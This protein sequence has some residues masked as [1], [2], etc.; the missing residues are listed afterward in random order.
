[1]P[2][3]QRRRRLAVWAAALV[4][5]A[6]LPTPSRAAVLSEDEIEETSTELGLVAR[7]FGFVL[8]GDVLDR[9]YN[10]LE[11]ASPSATNIFDLRPYFVR[12]TPHFHLVLHQSLTSVSRSHSSLGAFAF[13]R[14]GTPPRWFPLRHVFGETPT[15]SL[16]TETDWAYAAFIDGPVT[17]TIGRQPVTLGRGRIWRPWDL[18]STFTLTEVDTEYKPGVDAVRVDVS[19]S[20]SVTITA[21]G[22]AG[23]LERD[24]DFE[25]SPRGSTALGRVSFGFDGGEMAL[26][27][28]RVRQDD[29][30]GWSALWALP[31]F[32]LYGELSATWFHHDS[33]SSP[34]VAGR[35]VAV[36]RG[37]LGAT[38]KPSSKLT[39]VPEVYYDGFGAQRKEQYYAVALSERVAVGEQL[40]LGQ[41]YG[42]VALDFE[43]HPLV[44]ITGLAIDNL[45]DGSALLSAGVTYDAAANT[46]LKAGG[47]VPVGPKPDPKTLAPRSE[48]GMFPYFGFAE[49][50]VTL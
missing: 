15:L 21:I 10:F 8:A 1:M 2:H 43:A 14:G 35:Q 26:L 24:S 41:L 33:L 17:Y 9:P 20:S 12:R 23:E 29:V 4:A 25:T 5:L 32:D 44:H 6:S 13:G 37:L 34:A 47:Y 28:G 31:S 38:V 46:R 48:F 22:S 49:L 18:V 45:V 42:G 40:V 39:V 16:Q 11:D 7:G 50:E 3:D 27:G 19:P 36:P 30:L